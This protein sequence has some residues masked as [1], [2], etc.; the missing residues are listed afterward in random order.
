MRLV[1]FIPIH[2]EKSVC[3]RGILE[4]SS[5]PTFTVKST[6]RNREDSAM[7]IRFRVPYSSTRQRTFLGSI[8]ACSITCISM[9][10]SHIETGFVGITDN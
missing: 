2:R 9:V 4:R 8:K 7:C 10:Q 6:A 1:N 5:A 3:S